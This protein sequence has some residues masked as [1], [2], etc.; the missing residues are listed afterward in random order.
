MFG[1]LINPV[2]E[3]D[4]SLVGYLH[5]LGGAN[6]LWNGEIVKK[7]KE[8]T[9]A[10][11]YDWLGEDVRPVSW[12]EVAFEL[13]SPKFTNQKVWSLVHSK[14]CPHCLAAG[15]YWR[16]LWELSLYTSCS[17][18]K[19]DLLYR[20]PRCQAKANKSIILTMNCDSCGFSF[21][22]AS[23]PNLADKSA[24]WISGELSRRLRYGSNIGS[25]GIE[26]LTYKQFHFLAVRIGVRALSRKCSMNMTIASI[27]SKNVAPDIAKSAGSIL[28]GW[29]QNF[30]DLLA[31]LMKIRGSKL[32][33]KLGSTFGLIYH[34]V[35]LS[36]TDQ[37]YDF[38]RSEFERYIVENWEGPLDMRNRRL[39]ECTLLQH[40][41][42]PYNKA[43]Q[44]VGLPEKILRRMHFSGE[45]DAREF[46]YSCG[47]TVAVVDVEKAR[48]LSSLIREPLNLRE[49]SRLLCLSR[50]RI[51]QLIG[52]GILKY[53]GGA[54]LAGEKW[55][56]DYSSIVSLTPARFL[57]YPS[58]GFVTISQ[59]AKHYLP[60]SSG[61]VDLVMAIQSGKISVYCREAAEALNIGKW[62]INP[63]DL[64]R[65]QITRQASSHVKGM[66]VSKAAQE[67]GV[68]EQVAYALVRLGRLRSEMVQCSRRPAQLVSIEAI[69]HFNRNYILAPELALRLS[70]HMVKV[71]FQLQS[72]GFLPIAGPN[73]PHAQ[74]RQNVWRRSKKLMSYIS[75]AAEHY[76]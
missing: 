52:A 30:H 56:I 44:I 74:C 1:L 43:A 20:C 5:R 63:S 25:S 14:F 71:Q 72:G 70:V 19:V 65:N 12:Y 67:L 9:D 2:P 21:L 7:F 15:L 66:S 59:I 48:R 36:L 28:M 16:E 6:A 54:P 51:E 62:L 76:N 75:L 42:L 57:P 4:E 23:K 39:S 35:Y 31:D 38:V 33:P 22:E 10:K 73:V 50:K 68:K 8:L 53:V 40:R 55:M 27:V 32:S 24:L 17:V 60:T 37:S 46:R 11:V 29:P 26:S 18:H 3:L 58:D 13:R 47:K 49:T 69:Q 64:E 61:L 45:L 34:D 41:W